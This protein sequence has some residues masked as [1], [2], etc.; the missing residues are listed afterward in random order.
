MAGRPGVEGPVGVSAGEATAALVR[1]PP[2][3]PAA[4]SFLGLGNRDHRSASALGRTTVDGPLK[5][6]TEAA[7]ASVIDVIGGRPPALG[8]L[9][10]GI[11]DE[12]AAGAGPIGTIPTRPVWR[13]SVARRA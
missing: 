5:E 9:P 11:L 6:M 7:V 10:G 2:A 1:R 12:D 3:V 8:V 4:R 13:S